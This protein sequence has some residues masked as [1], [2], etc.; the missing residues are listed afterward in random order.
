MQVT[1]TEDLTNPT[2]DVF[3]KR[4]AALEGGVAALAVGIRS[5]STCICISRHLAHAGDHIV[6]AKTYLWWN[7]QPFSTYTYQIT[8]LK[9][10]S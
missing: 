2:E 7:I 3:E 6:A 4:I 10:H 5:S 8:A 1:F 9:L